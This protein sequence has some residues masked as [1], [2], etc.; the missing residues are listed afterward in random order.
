MMDLAAFRSEYPEFQ[1]CEDAF[2]SLYLA[3]A[4]KRIDRRIWGEIAA[5][6]HGFLTA[7]LI[8]TAPNGQMA[9]LV[10]ADGDTTYGKA[11]RDLVAQVACGLRVV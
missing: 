5:E 3:R 6:G 2:V 7:H 1:S 4:A 11:F 9:R 10:S 8:A